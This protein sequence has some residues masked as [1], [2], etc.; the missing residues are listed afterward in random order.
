MARANLSLTSV[1]N[2]VV[3]FPP[4]AEQKRIVAKVDTLMA[5]CDQLQDRIES[6]RSESEK[7]TASTIH[8][9]LAG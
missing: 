1:S 8:H 4:L 9:L 3:P 2:F 6:A 7:L 5:L